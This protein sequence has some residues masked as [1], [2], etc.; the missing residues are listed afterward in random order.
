[1]YLFDK[2][3]EEQSVRTSFEVAREQRAKTM[4]QRNEI[5]S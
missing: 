3:S 4:K 5:M 1:M 2:R